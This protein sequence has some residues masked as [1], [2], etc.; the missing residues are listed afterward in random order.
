MAA[1]PTRS[2][3]RPGLI[4]RRPGLTGNSFNRSSRTILQPGGIRT[5]APVVTGYEPY[6]P[7]YNPYFYGYGYPPY[8][9][10]LYYG[11]FS[12]GMGIAYTPNYSYYP[13]VYNDGYGSSSDNYSGGVVE[14]QV[15]GYVVYAMDTLRGLVTLGHKT[16]S[17]EN[18]DSGRNY[19]YKFRINQKQLTAVWA[20]NDERK[21]LDLV[22]LKNDHKQ[23]WRLIHEGKLNI[24][25]TRH[26]FIY[27]PD[28]ID[29][30][31]LAIVYNGKTIK[32]EAYSPTEAKERL[33]GLV[34]T[35]YE[36]KL[37]AGKYSWNELLIY[38]DKLD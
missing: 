31:S 24:Y 29:I 6:H 25:D 18:R 22:R 16:I 12:M 37:D 34:N 11:L 9:F 7:G 27:R 1:K 5:G 28:D 8:Y 20:T 19:D 17:L 10:G 32:L 26:D 4:G 21:Q 33:T 13:P 30:R 38:I 35:A 23:L 2:A 15:N 14:D 3:A 36:V